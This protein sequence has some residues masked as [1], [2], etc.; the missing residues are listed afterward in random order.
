[1][2]YNGTVHITNKCAYITYVCDYQ[3]PNVYLIGQQ[4]HWMT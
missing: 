4:K 3:H 2:V 1:M